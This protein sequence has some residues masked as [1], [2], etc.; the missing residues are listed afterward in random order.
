MLDNFTETSDFCTCCR[1]ATRHK[2][3]VE[4]SGVNFCLSS[5]AKEMSLSESQAVA[6]LLSVGVKVNLTAHPNLA[7]Y[8]QTSHEPPARTFAQVGR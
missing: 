5:F 4:A 2:A 3:I 1:G 7:A 6:F 8:Q